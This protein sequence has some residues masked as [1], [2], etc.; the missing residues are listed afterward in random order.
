MPPWS[1]E[2]LARI[3]DAEELEIA[4]LRH[5]GTLRPAVTIWIVRDGDELY[6]RS[7]NGPTSAWYRG[8]QAQHAGR[9]AAGGVE[10]AVAFEPAADDVNDA[11]DAAYRSKYARYSD[12]TLGRIMSRDARA[13]T[14]RLVPR[15][16]TAEENS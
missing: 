16:D 5:D 2:E 1:T 6:V 8:S 7:V 3:G 4:S 15:A 14:Y 10:M 11:I 12:R 9:I 13:T